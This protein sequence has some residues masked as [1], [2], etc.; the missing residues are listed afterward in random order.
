MIAL[1]ILDLR[2]GNN[3]RNDGKT[4]TGEVAFVIVVHKVPDMNFN[5]PLL[6]T[7]SY[8]RGGTYI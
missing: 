6:P 7:F 5:D 3:E 4:E 2:C 1:F 8:Q